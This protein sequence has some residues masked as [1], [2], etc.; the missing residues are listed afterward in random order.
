MRVPTVPRVSPFGS[1][2]TTRAGPPQRTGRCARTEPASGS[3]CLRV[4]A[5]TLRRFAGAFQRGRLG[6]AT[7]A[8][9]RLSRAAFF[10]LRSCRQRLTGLEPRPITL[11]P[12]ESGIERKSKE[13]ASATRSLIVSSSSTRFAARPRGLETR[14]VATI[15]SARR[16][17]ARRRRSASR[18]WRCLAAESAHVRHVHHIGE[19]SPAAG[20]DRPSD[21]EPL[22]RAASS[23]GRPGR[24]GVAGSRCR[25]RAEVRRGPSSRASCPSR[26]QV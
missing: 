19:R 1:S 9:L 8:S 6:R 5:R 12:S 4:H 11:D 14:C 7:T 18:T 22:L 21:R 20:G 25:G 24:R 17:R 26:A 3:P 23:L 13:S 10:F 15:L 2:A 16:R